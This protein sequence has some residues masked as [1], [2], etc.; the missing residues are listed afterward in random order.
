MMEVVSFSMGVQIGDVP[1]GDIDGASVHRF[2]GE[3]LLLGDE[4]RKVFQGDDE[5]VRRRH[6]VVG[7][8]TFVVD[9]DDRNEEFAAEARHQRHSLNADLIHSQ[10][11]WNQIPVFVLP[12]VINPIGI[13]L[14]C[15][16]GPFVITIADAID[17]FLADQD[18]VDVEFLFLGRF[19]R[20]G[21]DQIE[22]IVQR[23]LVDFF[24]IHL[25]RAPFAK[26]AFHDGGEEKVSE[27]GARQNGG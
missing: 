6:F 16:D 5:V 14:F 1:G 26:R 17:E 9:Q 13:V 11:I 22:I 12:R 2:N 23:D 15:A 7:Q 3:G 25:N 8:K 27:K 24:V 21:I 19:V 10:G 20:E 4:G 18:M